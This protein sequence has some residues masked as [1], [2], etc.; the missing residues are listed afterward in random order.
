MHFFLDA[1]AGAIKTIDTVGPTRDFVE[2]G[3]NTWAAVKRYLDDVAA[4]IPSGF[5]PV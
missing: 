4:T 3:E 5:T 1:A 2:Y